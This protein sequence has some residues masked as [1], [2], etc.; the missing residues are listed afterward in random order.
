MVCVVRL[1]SAMLSHSTLHQESH[2]TLHRALQPA[3]CS[4]VHTVALSVA[5]L[6]LKYGLSFKVL[7]ARLL[8]PGT[9]LA[10]CC[11]RGRVVHC[12]MDG[13]MLLVTTI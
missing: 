1:K 10:G 9:H 11:A 7:H 13:S 5:E 8:N 3:A 12:H 2:I 6:R 4:N